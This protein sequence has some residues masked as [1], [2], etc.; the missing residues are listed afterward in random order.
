MNNQ[1]EIEKLA[2]KGKAIVD[3]CAIEDRS[4]TPAEERQ[5]G[6]IHARLKELRDEQGHQKDVDGFRAGGGNAEE[7]RVDSP[8]PAGRLGDAFI[9]SKGYKSIKDA[10]TRGQ[11]WSSGPVEVPYQSKGTLMEG[12]VAGT[13]VPAQYQPG[14]VSKL[15]QPVGLADYF[16]QETTTSSHWRYALE[17]TAT[18]GAAGVAEGGTKPESTFNYSEV[19]E[20]VKKIAT[21]LPVSDELL[22]DAPAIQTY[23]NNRL[24][25][26]IQSEEERQLLLAPAPTSWSGSPGARGS[27]P[28]APPQAARSRSSRY[29]RRRRAAAAQPSWTPT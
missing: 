1:Q 5:L 2:E 13:L 12:S 7:I 28:T 19:D 11:T 9:R 27:T 4:R 23:I 21:S 15:F 16:G 25:L 18:S 26:F 6:E 14:I 20:P 3:C 17:G 24:S 22:E 8:A 29:S 10:Q